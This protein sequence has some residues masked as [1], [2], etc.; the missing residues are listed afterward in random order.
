MYF[1]EGGSVV[2]VKIS[3]KVKLL[4]YILNN[5][6]TWAALK[7]LLTGDAQKLDVRK[8]LNRTNIFLGPMGSWI[9]ELLTLGFRAK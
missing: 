5:N 1:Y 2:F 6:D 7:E 8:G 4:R 3:K 9:S